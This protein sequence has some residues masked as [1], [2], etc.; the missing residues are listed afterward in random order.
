MDGSPPK[1]TPR[2]SAKDLEPGALASA[3]ISKSRSQ[4]PLMDTPLSELNTTCGKKKKRAP[5]GSLKAETHGGVL[6]GGM[7]EREHIVES[8]V[9]TKRLRLLRVDLAVRLRR[10]LE[11]NRQ[12]ERKSRV[13]IL[14]FDPLF[15]G[16]FNQGFC[17]PL[18]KH[19]ED[20]GGGKGRGYSQ[21]SDSHGKTQQ[22][23]R[24]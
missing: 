11:G 21:D 4:N 14:I 16:I 5:A 23:R 17:L 19:L 6:F 3:L 10:G 8:P 18:R 20:S 13:L 7:V 12:K 9:R 22:A 24:L 15:V 1:P 2:S